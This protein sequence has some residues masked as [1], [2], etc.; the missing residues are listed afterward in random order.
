[1]QTRVIVVIVAAIVIA[2]GGGL[3]WWKSQSA[4]LPNMTS[5]AQQTPAPVEAP[6]TAEAELGEVPATPEV[7]NTQLPPLDSSDDY[8]REQVSPLS[9]AMAGWLKQDDLVQRFAVVI[10]NAGN[11][12]YPRRQLGFLAPQGK[13]AVTQQGDRLLLDPAGYHRFD[14]AV[15][16]A[17]SV[18]PQQAVALLRTLSPLLAESL[19]SLGAKDPDPVVAMRQAID[20]V[21]ATP[22]VEG[23][24]ELVQPKVYYQFADKKL[25]SLKPLQKQLLRMGPQNLERIKNYLMQI[26]ADL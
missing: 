21:L 18:A 2:I 16:T 4:A 3:W 15:D 9:P 23:D 7:Q 11:G 26:K 14:A 6:A 10:D 12:D 20:I 19:K 8:V 24:I 25:E 22:D 17:V 13:F 1:M 5:T